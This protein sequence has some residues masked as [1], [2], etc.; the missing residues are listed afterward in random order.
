MVDTTY[1]PK[2]YKNTG[3]DQMVVA[4]GGTILVETGGNVQ[5]DNVVKNIR[6]RFTVAEVNAGATILAAI[7]GYKYRMVDCT[8][9]AQGGSAATGTA[10]IIVGTQTSAV[11][12]VSFAQAQLTDDCYLK[13]GITGT[14]IL[15]NGVSFLANDANTAITIAK[16]GSSFATVT[17]FDVNFTYVIEAA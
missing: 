16:T 12:L 8:I 10:V 2:V 11:S 3:G 13:P 1:S 4:S 7:S 17:H 6:T 15:A 5:V 9:A 14:T